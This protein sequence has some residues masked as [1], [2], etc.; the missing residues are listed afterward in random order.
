MHALQVLL[1]SGAFFLEML[2]RDPTKYPNDAH[3]TQ[4]RAR[5]TTTLRDILAQMVNENCVSHQ[6][7]RNIS[8]LPLQSAL[9]KRVN[10][11]K[12][13]EDAEELLIYL[14]NEIFESATPWRNPAHCLQGPSV[15]TCECL[16]CHYKSSLAETPFFMWPIP[17]PSHCLEITVQSSSV[18]HFLIHACSR[19]L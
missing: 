4:L 16:K 11:G 2:E 13:Q 15:Q 18:I 12:T 19:R 9:D 14:L 10:N 1:F 6:S 17:L 3:E 8:T 5:N 7:R